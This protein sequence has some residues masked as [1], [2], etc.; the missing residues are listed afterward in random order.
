MSSEANLFLQPGGSYHQLPLYLA[1]ARLLRGRSVLDLSTGTGQGAALLADGRASE[2]VALCDADDGLRLAQRGNT[3]PNLRFLQGPADEA[4][5]PEQHFDAVLSLQG[6]F[7]PFQTAILQRVARVLAPQGVFLAAIPNPSRPGL[8]VP[9]CMAQPEPVAISAHQLM[10]ELKRHFSQ[11]RLLGHVPVLGFLL[12]ELASTEAALQHATLEPALLGG[13]LDE[14]YAWIALCSN[15]AQSAIDPTLVRLRFDDLARVLRRQLEEGLEQAGRVIGDAPAMAGYQDRLVA[16][17]R[18]VGMATAGIAASPSPEGGRTADDD[19]AEGDWGDLPSAGGDDDDPRAE[20]LPGVAIPVLTPQPA[21]AE[22]PEFDPGPPPSAAFIPVSEDDDADD[23]DET[24]TPPPQSDAGAG[25]IPWQVAAHLRSSLERLE[26][27][28]A[29]CAVHAE[30]AQRSLADRA[31][32][33]PALHAE[34]GRLLE[35][36]R[37]QDEEL[38]SLRAAAAERAALL[39]EAEAQRA[40]RDAALHADLKAELGAAQDS[41]RQLVR[42][43]QERAEEQRAL[44]GRV[45]EGAVERQRLRARLAELEPME[46]SGSVRVT[47]LQLASLREERGLLEQ[48]LRRL[49]EENGRLRLEL[50]AAN[51]ALATLPPT[52]DTEL[53][54]QLVAERR[55][56]EQLSGLLGERV[57]QIEQALLAGRRRVEEV[58]AWVD[59]ARGRLGRIEGAAD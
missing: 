40:Q 50:E 9:G 46:R 2:V 33:E 23:A 53:E 5:L 24:P 52:R 54:A 43:L 37:S 39:A 42:E 30:V 15:S 3:L 41:I 36:L 6:P 11:V 27:F 1:L 16:M 4:P 47:M 12:H 31:G 8:P 51:E 55:Q 34:V 58:A 14:A 19:D 28:L 57:E 29:D 20:F 26:Y 7:D 13:E 48:E 10:L 21:S 32:V 25:G 18:L 44:Q 35:R 22:E 38:V 49:D 59:D 45:A 17:H 56:R